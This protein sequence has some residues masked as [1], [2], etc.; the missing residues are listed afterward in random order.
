MERASLLFISPIGLHSI[1]S[2]LGRLLVFYSVLLA[3]VS[4]S[5][6]TKFLLTLKATQFLKNVTSET[7]FRCTL[8]QRSH[9]LLK[10]FGPIKKGCRTN[11]LS[12]G[13]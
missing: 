7:S 6:A 1:M 3:I 12:I 11:F 4:R 9:Q 5:I 10:R 13:K 8:L 2:V